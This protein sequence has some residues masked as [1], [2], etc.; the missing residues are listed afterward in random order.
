MFQFKVSDLCNITRF[1]GTYFH[2]WKYNIKLVL[3]SENLLKIDEGV[4]IELVSPPTTLGGTI[5]HLPPTK[6]GSKNKFL[7][8]D[9]HPLTIIA[10][11]LDNSQVFHINSCNTTKET[12]DEGLLFV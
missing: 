11:C 7:Q 9:T 12:W 8:N 10:N 1:D 6:L 3:K 4:K 5:H 2:V